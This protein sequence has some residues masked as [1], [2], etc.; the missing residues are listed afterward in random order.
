MQLHLFILGGKRA[1]P[2]TTVGNL[3]QSRQLLA[4]RSND[5]R[6]LEISP[7]INPNYSQASMA[8]TSLKFAPFGRGT[9]QQRRAPYLG[10]Y[11][12]YADPFTHC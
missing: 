7:V 4:S 2:S 11:G 3:A 5:V 8:N 10:R 9:R 6:W 12:S 1:L